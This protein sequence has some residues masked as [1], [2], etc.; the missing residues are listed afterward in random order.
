MSSLPSNSPA[1]EAPLSTSLWDPVTPAHHVL[2]DPVLLP[3]LRPS[4]LLFPLPGM[5]FPL[6]LPV[7]LLYILLK[8]SQ[9]MS[10]WHP[11]TGWFPHVYSRKHV[12]CW[13]TSLTGT[14]VLWR[15]LPHVFLL[16]SPEFC[17]PSAKLT[18]EA[19]VGHVCRMDEQSDWPLLLVPILVNKKPLKG[20]SAS[21]LEKPSPV[22][23]GSVGFSSRPL[24]NFIYL[25]EHDIR[26]TTISYTTK[27]S[28]EM[29]PI[30]IK[31]CIPLSEM[32]KM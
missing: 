24:H 13:S 2:K 21:F 18:G 17:S 6:C 20:P 14:R 7:W 26:H 12:D 4:Y 32:L 16:G 27:T 15:L 28:W 8:R 25:L 5:L 11:Q 19:H 22:P 31:I 3:T 29:L 1:P 9:L 10:S 23:P 30:L